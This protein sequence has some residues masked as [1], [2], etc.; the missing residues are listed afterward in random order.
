VIVVVFFVRNHFSIIF[1]LYTQLPLVIETVVFE[2][3]LIVSPIGAI[4]AVEF[5]FFLYIL[6]NLYILVES[7]LK[8][9]CL[10]QTF[11]HAL[12]LKFSPDAT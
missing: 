6:V 1:F 8:R 11:S 12:A 9:N 2:L 3:L 4:S 10:L 7:L 5:K